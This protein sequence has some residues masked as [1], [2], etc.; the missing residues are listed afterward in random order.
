MKAVIK[1]RTSGKSIRKR[2]SK[3]KAGKK[4]TGFEKAWAFWKTIQ[5]DMSGFKFN[6][7]ESNA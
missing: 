3:Q 4:V 2:A 1:K 6:R 5:V 7:E